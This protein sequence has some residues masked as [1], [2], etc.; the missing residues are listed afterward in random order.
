MTQNEYHGERITL[1]DSIIGA[2]LKMAN[3]SNQATSKIV[4]VY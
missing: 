2:I 3:I 1:S 4:V